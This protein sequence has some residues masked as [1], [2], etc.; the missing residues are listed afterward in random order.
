MAAT[1]AEVITNLSNKLAALTQSSSEQGLAFAGA[2]LQERTDLQAQMYATGLEQTACQ[3]RIQDLQAAQ[4][5]VDP[6]AG[7]EANL[8]AAI[9]AVGALVAATAAARAVITA[10]DNLVKAYTAKSTKP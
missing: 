2:T 1:A 10:A 7:E 8:L 5:Y 9:G 6:G 4:A 3:Q